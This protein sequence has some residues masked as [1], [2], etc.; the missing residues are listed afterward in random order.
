MLISAF[1]IYIDKS[2]F[3]N[4]RECTA[5]KMN[6]PFKNFFSKF[7][8]ICKKL[9]ILSYFLKKS[10]MENFIFCVVVAGMTYKSGSTIKSWKKWYSVKRIRIWSYSG[11]HFPAFGLNTER[12]SVCESLHHEI[13]YRKIRTRNNFVFGH[14]SRSA[15]ITINAKISFDT[16]LSNPWKSKQNEQV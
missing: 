7:E 14:F 12:Y 10:L 9:R 6:F 5:Q 15:G 4:G 8:Q 13:E 16:H 3:V 11:P 1:N 2:C